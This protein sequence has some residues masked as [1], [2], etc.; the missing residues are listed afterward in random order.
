MLHYWS[1]QNLDLRGSWLTIGSFDGVHLGHLTLL[2]ELISGAHAEGLTAVV[3]TFHPHPAVVLNK[4]KDFSYLS[5]PEG[6]AGL[7]ERAGVDV[8]ITHPFSLQVA[9]ISA[10]DFIQNIIQNLK[11]RHLCVGHDFALGRGREGDLPAL[12]HLGDELGYTISVVEP[13][14]LDGQ[15]VSSSRV[16]QALLDGEVELAHRLLGRPYKIIG[17]VV[18]GD[19]RGRSL[20]FPTANLEVWAERTLPKP[21]VY[22]CWAAIDGK[23]YPAVTNVGFRPTFDNQPLRPRVEAFL[24]DFEGNLYH[25]TM[26]LSFIRRLRDEVRF[27]DIQ[28][29]IDQMHRDVQVGRQMLEVAQ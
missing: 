26:R 17:E 10:H 28:A 4:R 24:L 13:V 16:R 1:L 2:K 9:Q 21:G 11:M 29:L 5:S 15:V 18:H 8:V 23:D 3:L 19:S 12:T 14:M 25:R 7:L 20:G 27:N 6:K 22:A